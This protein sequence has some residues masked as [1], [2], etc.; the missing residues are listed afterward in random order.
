MPA[1]KVGE[2]CS[3]LVIRKVAGVFDDCTTG[4]GGILGGILC[5]GSLGGKGGSSVIADCGSVSWEGLEGSG[6]GEQ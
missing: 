3:G 1:R 4:F 2:K 5:R 6:R